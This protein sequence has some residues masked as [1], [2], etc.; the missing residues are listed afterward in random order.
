MTHAVYPGSF[1]PPT[2]GHLDVIRRAA[3][4]FNT[5]TVA[6][7][8]NPQKREPLFTIAE[9]KAMLEECVRDLG[10]VRVAEFHG[11]LADYIK[12]SGAD[13]IVKGLRIVADFEAEFATALM[14][15]SLSGIDTTFLMSDAKYSFVSSSLVKEVFL[16]G[17]DV[18]TYVPE[19]ALHMME[20]RAPAR[21]DQS[22]SPK[23]SHE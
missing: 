23:H 10:N 4:I 5:V 6:V 18:S 22:V 2:R 17:G 7:V 1:D 9:R 19:A 11:L 3:A 12:T 14:N 8:V 20:E 15:R 16:L 21:S 13:V